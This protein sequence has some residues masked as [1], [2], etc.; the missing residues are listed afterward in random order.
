MAQAIRELSTERG[1]DVARFS[2]LA[3][4]G[5]GGLFAPWLLRDLGLREALIP[6]HPGVFAALGLHYADLRHHA[7]APLP[8]ALDGLDPDRLRSV[9]AELAASLDAALDRDGVGRRARRMTFSA[10]MRY[11]GQHHR[12]EVPLPAPEALGDASSGRLGGDFHDLHERRYGYCHR[13]ISRWRSPTC[14]RWASA[15]SRDRRARCRTPRAG[16]I[17]RRAR[18]AARTARCRNE[19]G[20]DARLPPRRPGGGVASRRT[21]H[22]RAGRQY[23][24]GPRRSRTARA[25]RLGFI[26]VTEEPAEGSP[27]RIASDGAS[28]R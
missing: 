24:R 11:V 1:D 9:L 3:F 15:C 8:V 28:A 21:G 10:D 12:L 13:G 6:R 2:L 16:S 17:R 18:G 20:A 14:T 27:A 7:Q 23:T 22:R 26:H 4:G 5:A 19:P 25:G